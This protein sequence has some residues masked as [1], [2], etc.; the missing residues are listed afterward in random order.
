[1]KTLI[2]TCFLITIV[3][4]FSTTVV[5]AGLYDTPKTK[6]L[7][8][9]AYPTYAV[10]ILPEE[11]LNPNGCTFTIG[12]MNAGNFIAIQF[13]EV[14]GKEMYAAL[15]AAFMADKSV[16]FGIDSCFT[17]GSATIPNAY[18]IQIYHD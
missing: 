11:V 17:W 7:Y 18:R 2:K 10:A 4:I 14:A 15:L 9:R 1:M 5:R 6:V 16:S 8:L 3:M 12:D 13:N